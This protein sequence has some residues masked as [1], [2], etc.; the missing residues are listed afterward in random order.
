MPVSTFGALF[1]GYWENFSNRECHVSNVLVSRRFTG[2]FKLNLTVSYG[3]YLGPDQNG[4]FG[5]V[6]KLFFLNFG[7]I[8]FFSWVNMQPLLLSVL[9]RTFGLLSI[10]GLSTHA[11]V[12]FFFCSTPLLK[13]I[14]QLLAYSLFSVTTSLVEHSAY[15]VSTGMGVFLL[16]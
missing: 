9:A 7:A 6:V 16:L 13:N 8:R 11:G 1:S 2:Y 5:S 14:M 4:L 10:R 12:F 15:S 3:F